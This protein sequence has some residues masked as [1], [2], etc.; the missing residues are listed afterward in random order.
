MIAAAARPS[1]QRIA[2]PRALIAATPRTRRAMT[3]GT[4]TCRVA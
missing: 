2:V 4:I 1:A 3:A